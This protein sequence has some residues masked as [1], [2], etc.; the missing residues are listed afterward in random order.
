M[1]DTSALLEGHHLVTS[2]PGAWCQCGHHL[3]WKT[4]EEDHSVHVV[5]EIGAQALDE[6][7][8][9]ATGLGTWSGSNIAVGDRASTWLA[10]RAAAMR[11]PR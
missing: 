10:G 9:A 7:S 4:R 1:T 8:A 6:A 2:D 5:I 3:E 11:S